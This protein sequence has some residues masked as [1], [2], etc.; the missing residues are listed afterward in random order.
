[1]EMLTHT[2]SCR[3]IFMNVIIATSVKA[4]GYEYENTYSK[5]HVK[6][7]ASLTSMSIA[8]SSQ[9]SSPL[10]LDAFKHCRKGLFG[11]ALSLFEHIMSTSTD[12]E[13]KYIARKF[14]SSILLKKKKELKMDEYVY[15][16]KLARCYIMDKFDDPV[17]PQLNEYS[18]SYYYFSNSFQRNYTFHRKYPSEWRKWIPY[19]ANPHFEDVGWGIHG[20]DISIFY[21]D[22]FLRYR[23]LETLRY[24]QK[25]NNLYGFVDENGNSIIPPQFA[26]AYPFDEIH[27]LAAI[28]Y[29]N[30]K[31]GYIDLHG[32]FVV[33]PSYD[34]VS[35]VFVDG[36]T[37][38]IK[39][40]WL[41]VIDKKGQI[42]KSLYGYTDISH[43]MEKNAVLAKNTRKKE[44][45]FDLIDFEGNI[46]KE[47]VL[48]KKNIKESYYNSYE[49]E[50]LYANYEN[51]FGCSFSLKNYKKTIGE[52][53]PNSEELEIYC[54]VLILVDSF[55][56][57]S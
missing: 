1:M 30:G 19:V 24:P 16:Y 34:V 56:F 33:E 23:Q 10:F 13:E 37:L 55:V 28:M 31:W 44:P 43:K 12:E 26:F 32:Q 5:Q 53:I 54:C 41:I 38:V 46:I 8:E 52:I 7:N 11:S 20:S 50:K 57:Y 29:T 27:G 40:G 14:A 22:F 25:T 18:Y 45:R 21:R 39:D 36:K 4:S 6:K 35:D 9:E 15:N 48:N 3:T 47:D 2:K 17:Y 51:C 42:I 49:V